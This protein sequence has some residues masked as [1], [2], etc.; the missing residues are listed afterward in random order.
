MKQKYFYFLIIVWI[1]IDLG[2]KQLALRCIHG[3]IDIFWNFLQLAYYENDGIA[4][5]IDIPFLKIATIILILAI[6]VYYKK[7]E[8]QKKNPLIDTAFALVLSGAIGNGIERIFQNY[9]ID[10]I[11]VKG[12]SV[13]NLADSYISIWAFLYIVALLLEQKKK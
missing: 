4:F 2:T 11:S 12:F 10:F 3:P 7:E 5:S 1:L 13:F 6:F 8:Q 9:V